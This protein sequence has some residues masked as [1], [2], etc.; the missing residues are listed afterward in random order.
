MNSTPAVTLAR[1]VNDFNKYT[2]NSN[3]E[4]EYFFGLTVQNG[5]LHY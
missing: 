5:S 3:Q 1:H 2:C 4:I